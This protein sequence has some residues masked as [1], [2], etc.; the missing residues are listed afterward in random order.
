MAVDLARRGMNVCVIARTKSKLEEVADEIKQHNVEAKVVAFD[1][2]ETSAHSYKKMFH[3]L[4]SIDIGVLV[5]NVGINYE[6]PKDYDSVPIEED[7]RILNVN[8]ES[9]LQMTK[10]VVPRMKAKRCGAIINMGS[11]SGVTPTAMLATYA[12]S[13]S[14]NAHFSNC[15][16]VELKPHGIDVLTVRPNL[17]ITN[18]TIGAGN[19]TPKPSFLRVATIPAVRQILSKVG[20]VMMTAGH[21]NHCLI[22]ALVTSAPVSFVNNQILK[23]HKSIN[24]RAQR[25]KEAQTAAQK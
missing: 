4:D 17:I 5:N 2:S 21:P 8:C 10:Y 25:K 6:F 16:A 20:T 23:M 9:Q 1:F 11:F 3:E 24:K 19:K 22:E 15:L 12:A 7:T 13:K 14:F 18:M